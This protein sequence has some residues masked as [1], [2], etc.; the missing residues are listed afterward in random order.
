MVPLLAALGGLIFWWRK[1]RRTTDYVESR[2]VKA[3]LPWWVKNIESLVAFVC[4]W[5]L[6]M[7]TV[8]I[9]SL[10]LRPPRSPASLVGAPAVYEVLGIGFVIVPMALLCANAVSWIVPGLRNANRQAFRGTYVS[11]TTANSG[12]IKGASFSVPLGLVMLYIAA[13]LPLTG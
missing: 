11:F 8:K 9:Y 7:A 5:L 1:R 10:L 13:N 2:A 4:G 3:R 6:A 12:L